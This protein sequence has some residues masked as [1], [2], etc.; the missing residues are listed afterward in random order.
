MRRARAFCCTAV[1]GL[2]LL[3]SA[4]SASALGIHGDS[5]STGP[6]APDPIDG[7]GGWDGGQP[8]GAD[9]TTT[10]SWEIAVLDTHVNYKY[11]FTHPEH[12]ASHLIL[13]VSDDFLLSDVLQIY[14]GLTLADL[15]LDTYWGS[16]NDNQGMPGAVYA[17]KFDA[18]SSYTDN[19]DGTI[20]ETIE[21][22]STKLPT[23]GDF[24]VR[25]GRDFGDPGG[26]RERDAAWNV[27]FLSEET[28]HYNDINDGFHIAVPDSI[29]RTTHAPEPSTALL[30]GA[31]LAGLAW[32]RHRA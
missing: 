20:T 17:L 2:V 6:P 24:Y 5:I 7:T 21:F 27:G 22:D 26:D 9:P 12:D 13:E 30:L 16:G 10:L 29:V 19:G 3:G 14:G 31:G 11:S 4:G 25:G 23:W 1:L 28:T 18:F 32:R 8:G 15:E